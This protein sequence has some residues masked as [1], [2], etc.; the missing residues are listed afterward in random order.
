MWRVVQVGGRKWEELPWKLVAE[1]GQRVVV[2]VPVVG[3]LAV[4]L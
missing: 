1:E 4:E 3:E 2:V